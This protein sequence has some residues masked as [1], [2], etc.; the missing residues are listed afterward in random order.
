MPD[1]LRPEPIEPLDEFLRAC[2]RVEVDAEDRA[3]IVAAGARIQE[4]SEITMAADRH[5]LAPLVWQHARASGV[6]LSSARQSLGAVV[7]RHRD[8]GRAQADGLGEIVDALDRAGIDHLLLKGAILAHV[9]YP[10][11]DLRPMSDLDILVRPADAR[12][13]LEVTG[14]LG[15][16]AGSGPAPAQRFHHHLPMATR[17]RDGLTVGVEI[18]TNAL[19]HDQPMA[20][21]LGSLSQPPRECMIGG[22]RLRSLGHVDMLVHLSRHVLEPRQQTRLLNVA[23]LVGYAA[24]YASEID[25]DFLRQRQPHVVNTLAL[26]HF[27]TALP[28]ALRA[29]RPAESLGAPRGVGRGLTP[30]SSLE[31][32]RRGVGRAL[33][34][35]LYPPEWWLR[36]YYGVPPHR[37]LFAVR[38]QRHPWRIACWITRRVVASAVTRPVRTGEPG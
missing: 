1:S 14:R 17:R 5:G 20:L 29:L 15:F 37:S 34:D 7:L 38:W 25:W 16:D 26:M 19:S 12:H 32:R 13:A 9:L 24:K 27:V 11:S 31:I 2:A 30:L 4:W 21:R 3:R 10:R 8:L 23:D 35:L 28:E 22:R 36:L 6:D 33:G 18:H